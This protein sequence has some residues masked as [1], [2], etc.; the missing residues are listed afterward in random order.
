MRSVA[1]TSARC[2]GCTSYFSENVAYHWGILVKVSKGRLC[3]ISWFDSSEVVTFSLK[4]F[5]KTT[6]ARMFSEEVTKRQMN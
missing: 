4:K 2:P 5:L 6:T 3:I 1:L